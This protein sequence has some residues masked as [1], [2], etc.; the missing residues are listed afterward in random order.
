M[1]FQLECYY[2]DL[3][4]FYSTLE[5]EDIFDPESKETDGNNF[6]RWT[7]WSF[8]NIVI[9]LKFFLYKEAVFSA[10][11]RGSFI[12]ICYQMCNL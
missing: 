10:V 12:L 11:Y 9:C 8:S 6:Q 4:N 3:S 5:R 7:N 1:I 2:S